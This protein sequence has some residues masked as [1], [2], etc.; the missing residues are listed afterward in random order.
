MAAKKYRSLLQL[1]TFLYSPDGDYDPNA[2]NANGLRYGSRR[3]L[4]KKAAAADDELQLRDGL[5]AITMPDAPPAPRSTTTNIAVN[6]HHHIMA[7]EETLNASEK[8]SMYADE[9]PMS[10][11]VYEEN[12]INEKPMGKT[13]SNEKLSYS[14]SRLSLQETR[15][16]GAGND[17]DGGA[18]GGDVRRRNGNRGGSTSMDAM[19]DN[20][21][22]RAVKQPLTRSSNADVTIMIPTEKQLMQRSVSA[23]KPSNQ[24]Q[25]FNGLRRHAT[26]RN[27]NY[28]RNMRIH[29][30]SIHYRGAMLNTHRYRLRASSCPNIYRNS[31]TT[32]AREVEEVFVLYK[33]KKHP[34]EG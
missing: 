26:L 10:S 17:D 30:N 13:W 23:K 18:G 4:R 15:D 16:D 22:Q 8:F 32:L 27:S 29:R 14:E 20:N 24:L 11:S 5:L 21:V 9:R 6:P 7:S 31:M 1:P 28:L 3:S 34:D 2:I 25:Q 33:W 19:Y 12:F